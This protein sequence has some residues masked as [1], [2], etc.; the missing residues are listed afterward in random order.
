M[1][2]LVAYIDAG[3]GSLVVQVVIASIVAVPYFLRTQ[4]RTV[5]RELRSRFGRGTG[6]ADESAGR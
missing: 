3:S 4:L 6:P 2:H 1:D 5:V